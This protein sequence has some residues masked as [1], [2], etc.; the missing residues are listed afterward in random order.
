MRL[1]RSLLVFQLICGFPIFVS[2]QQSS[3]ITSYVR[4]FENGKIL[5]QQKNYSSARQ[6]LKTFVQQKEDA[7]LIQEAEY[8]IACTSYELNESNRIA[9]L[10]GYLE[11]YPESRHANRVNSLI[12]SAYYFDKE[13]KEAISLFDGCDPSQLS[14]EECQD[15][16]FRKAMSYLQ[17]GNLVQSATW[18]RTLQH[19]GNNY[20]ADCIYY[21]SYIDY[22]QKGYESALTGFLSLKADPVYGEL[23]PVFIGEM[24]LK[25][26]KYA[27]AEKEA[28]DCIVRYPNGKQNAQLQRIL[29]EACFYS[30]QY[31]KAVDALNQYAGA[32]EEPSREALYLLGLSYYETNVYSQAAETLGRVVTVKDALTQN[33]YL[34]LGLSYLQL[35]EKNKARMAFE[36]ASSVDYNM[37]VK[38]LA[39]YNYA[40]CIHET[41]YSAFGESV[42]VFERFLNEFPSS[43]YAEKVSDYLVEVYMNSKSYAAALKSIEKISRPGARIM[44]AKQNVLFQLGTE[45]FA[46]ADF[47][48][49]I[50]YFDRAL[51]IGQYNAQTKA[52]T[53]Y[54]RAE[55]YYRQGKYTQAGQGFQSYLQLTAQKATEMYALAHYNMGYVNFKQQNYRNALSWFQKYTSLVNGES[56]KTVL[57]DAYNRLGDCYFYDREFTTA[58][59]NYSKAVATDPSAG[60]YALYQDAFVAGLQKNY[61][62]KISLLNQL[63]QKYPSSQ[64]MDHALYE[65]GRACVMAGYNQQAIASFEELLQRFPTSDISRTGASEI[66]LLYYQQDDYGKA[67]KAYKKVIADYPGSEEARMA[68]RD[69]KSIYIDLNKTDEFISF[70]QT[71]SGAGT[72]DMSEQDSITYQ[73][74]EKVYM[75]GDNESAG[76]S[77]LSYLQNFPAGAFSVNAHYYLSVIYAGKKDVAAALEHSGKVL[78]YSDNEFSEEAMIINSGL[79][80]DEKK[81]QEALQVYKRLKEKTSSAENR[82][83]A[84]VGILRSSFNSG[85][86]KE[87]IGAATE[88]LANKKLSPELVNEATYDRAKSYLA[89]QDEKNALK[90][91]QTLAKDTRTLYG[92]EAKYLVAQLYFN[93]GNKA[94]AEKEVLNYIDQST[95]HVYWLARGFVLLS[96]IYASMN[97]KLDAKQYLLS[98]K[99]NYTEKDDIQEMI[100]N[101][102]EKLK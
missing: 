83:M 15:V 3:T 88:L 80:M 102:L 63:M 35:V 10:R 32:T 57:A 92:A 45:S 75:K 26:K 54:W 64:Y 13:Y 53:Y 60:D 24:Y 46:N 40:L 14:N 37:K 70:S 21:L 27:E 50:S 89:L 49:A 44:E 33:A 98:L 5:F 20:S 95:P 73:A 23:A 18:F 77:F 66:G 81:Y 96:D 1:R 48:K 39:M 67:I 94:L 62:E 19:L 31:P 97:K 84:Q 34:H 51:E 52:D 87:A 68:M 11:K 91:L 2:A 61:S 76:K 69:L 41:S 38:E 78:S 93:A 59:R 90:D 22:T 4:T 30:A 43:V 55:A 29:G 8:M 17:L 9:V 71:T 82:S 28:L 72:F 86:Y 6:M 36:Q 58:R 85:I 56:G 99:E 42:K 12:A 100:N 16:T 79:L 7:D 74:A 47:V 65:R 101:R 25:Q